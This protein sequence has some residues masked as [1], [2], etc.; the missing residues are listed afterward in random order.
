MSLLSHYI[1]KE[2]SKKYT[3]CEFFKVDV[4]ENT[5]SYNATWYGH[6]LLEFL[7]TQDVSEEQG[8]S[9]MPTFMFYRNSKKVQL[10]CVDRLY[11]M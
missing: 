11:P 1:L 6:G 4:D 10:K 2:L 7:S 3:D 9:A 5:V 8:I